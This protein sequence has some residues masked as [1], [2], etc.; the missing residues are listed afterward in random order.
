[1]HLRSVFA[2]FYKSFNFDYL[3]KYSGA[4]ER[5]QWEIIDNRWYPY[6]RVAVD[7][8]VTTV[9]GANESGKTHLLTAIEK[10]ISGKGITRDDFCRYSA[11]F[12]VERGKMRWPDFGL[13]WGGLSEDERRKLLAACGEEDIEVDSFLLF[14]N[15]LDK[16]TVCLR[17]DE[18]W[19]TYQVSDL[20]GLLP[21]VFRL[22]ENVALPESIPIRWL[23][24]RGEAL[25]PVERV[26]R[27]R[28]I[29]LLQTLIG[30]PEWFTTKATVTQSAEDISNA[31]GD[32]SSSQTEPSAR[33]AELGLARDLLLKV[34]GVDPDAF[35]ELLE[36][37]QDGRDAFANG[38]TD[39]INNALADRL[40][41]PRW[42]VQDREFKLMVSPRDF[43]L[44]FTIQD[45]TGTE[46]SFGERSMGLRYFLSYYIQYLAH[47]PPDGR[48]EILLMD[49]P[50]AYL[51]QQGQQDLLKIFQAFAEPEG[52]RDPIQVIYVTHSPFLIDRNHAERIR[53]LEKGVGD[54]GTRVVRDVS[55][56][57]YEPLRS[58][59]GSFVG[60]TTFIGNCNLMVEGPSDQVLLAG[61][62]TF[63]RRRQAGDLNSLDLNS[64]TIVPA[65]GASHVPYLVYLARGRDVE[66]PAMTVLLDSD[67]AGDDA[68]AAL[69]KGGARGKQLIDPKYV[70]QI[71]ELA[72]TPGI[73]TATGQ[74]PIEPE[75]LIPVAICVAAA[76]RY[77]KEVCGAGEDAVSLL[78]EDRLREKL[79]QGKS[80]FSA[81][82]KC[83]KALNE[84]WHVEKLG[85]A[86]ATL[87]TISQ[88]VESPGGEGLTDE[89]VA[90]FE[91]NMKCLFR[92]L[93]ERQRAAE[94]DLG[95]ERVSHRVERAK[96]AFL[97]DHPTGARREQAVIALEEIEAALDD[98]PESDQVKIGMVAIR[99]DFGLSETAVEMVPSYDSFRD[100]LDSLKYAGVLAVQDQPEKESQ[101]PAS[102]AA[103]PHPPAEDGDAVVAQQNGAAVA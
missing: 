11:F 2:R 87:E 78:N 82:E 102:A 57:H 100:R 52:S 66:R 93:R 37:L 81:I 101:A 44:A 84:E 85:F 20:T 50:D 4:T 9:V 53:V 10:G 67:K 70:F 79:E 103:V 54:E 88:Q 99:R 92:V 98:S 36:A 7:R 46:Y 63:V 19:R 74:N 90:Q 83:L 3:R 80:V 43:D 31:I 64:L 26:G 14:R 60:E 18:S 51:S 96:Q 41:F 30:N 1:M 72:G 21:V 86:R 13:E 35:G 75:D 73:L 25:P 27:R 95:A 23:S 65:G 12:T 15:D 42:W 58:A 24:S 22:K 49:E 6:V 39:K 28:R 69:K 17:R 8:Q 76:K 16:L 89:A 48:G 38:I 97:R 32:L 59:F 68:R 33:E 29:D 91:T 56:N 5:P 45:R 71:G 77:L 62:N 40:N 34:A 61:A 55:R 94:R 47:E